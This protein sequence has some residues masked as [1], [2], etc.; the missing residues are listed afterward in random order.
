MQIVKKMAL[1][2]VASAFVAGALAGCGEKTTGEKVG[3]KV[4]AAKDD[5][6]DA[7]PK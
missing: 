4:D 5:A 6:K 2:L 1:V 7:A 3:E